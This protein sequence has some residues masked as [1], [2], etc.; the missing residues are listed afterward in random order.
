M[1]KTIDKPKPNSVP[2]K[3]LLHH[4]F[5]QKYPYQDF[6]IFNYLLYV[7]I[8][9]DSLVSNSQ[10][11]IE[12]VTFNRKLLLILSYRLINNVC[13]FVIDIIDALI[14]CTPIP[15]FLNPVN[16][17]LSGPRDVLPLILTVPTSK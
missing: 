2:L 4:F 17:K 9:I 7:P 14:P 1:Q 3:G 8:L 12:K 13:G 10:F 5:K 6:D 16:G 15:E 11:Y